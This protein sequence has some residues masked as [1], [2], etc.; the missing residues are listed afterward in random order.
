MSKLDFFSIKLKRPKDDMSVNVII[1]QTHF[2]KSV[3]DIHEALVNSVP[4]IQFGVAFCEASGKKLIRY[5]GTHE[6]MKDLAIENAKKI[7]AGHVFVLFLKDVFPINV[8]NDLKRVPWKFAE[9][10]APQRTLW[11]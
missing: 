4:G 8:L 3:E 6:K 10:F 1:G 11:K 9:Y 5:S 7:K 2:I